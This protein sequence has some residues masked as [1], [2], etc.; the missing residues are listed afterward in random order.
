MLMDERATAEDI[1]A[2][3]FEIATGYMGLTERDGYLSERS[4]RT[5]KLLVAMRPDFGTH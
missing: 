5:A 4:T 3:L 1:A 2:Y